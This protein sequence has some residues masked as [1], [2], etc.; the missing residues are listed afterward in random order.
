MIQYMQMS[1]STQLKPLLEVGNDLVKHSIQNPT[2]APGVVTQLFPHIYEAAAR[3]SSRAIAV[4]LSKTH[5]VGISASTVSR[6][7]RSPDVHV[8]VYLDRVEP[9]ARG[10]AEALRISDFRLLLRSE[11]DFLGASKLTPHFPQTTKESHDQA[12]DDFE[13][14]KQILEREWW[15]YGDRFRVLALEVLRVRETEEENEDEND[16]PCND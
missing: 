10:M 3:M 13:E 6:A 11:G 8:E 16:D 12:E 4:Y 14:A 1:N 2:S 7:L 5:K 9:A 15:A